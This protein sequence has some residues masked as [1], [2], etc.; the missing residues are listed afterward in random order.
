MY[1]TR[2]R[3]CA[4]DILAGAGLSIVDKDRR[5]KIQALV[6]RG[7]TEG[8]RAAATAALARLTLADLPAFLAMWR[9]SEAYRYASGFTDAKPERDGVAFYVA[10][11]FGARWLDAR[12]E[13]LPIAA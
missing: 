4:A 8:E 12:A 11:G 7:A 9:P 1:K 6:E 2:V 10:R 5:A 13:P 3:V